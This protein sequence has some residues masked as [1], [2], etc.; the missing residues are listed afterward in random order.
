MDK[1]QT[2]VCTGVQILAYKPKQQKLQIRQSM[3]SSNTFTYPFNQ[4]KRIQK[5]KDIVEYQGC[6]PFYAGTVQRQAR[7]GGRSRRTDIWIRSSGA[8]CH[9][10]SRGGS[11]PTFFDLC[12]QPG[13]IRPVVVRRRC[14][15]QA[16]PI[17]RK[18]VR[19]NWSPS[20]GELSTTWISYFLYKWRRTSW[21]S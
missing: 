15:A 14:K 16:S 10:C 9:K 2:K 3:A 8:V 21:C 5:R 17:Q 19:Y 13:N 12:I 18:S 1:V 6:R 7:P 11:T 4:G 20:Q